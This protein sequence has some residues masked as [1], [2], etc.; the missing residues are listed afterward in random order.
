MGLKPTLAIPGSCLFYFI[1][2][3]D[4]VLYFFLNLLEIFQFLLDLSGHLAFQFVQP[5]LDIKKI[6]TLATSLE[7]KF[8]LLLCLPKIL[9]FDGMQRLML[10]KTTPTCKISI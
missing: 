4:S 5:N 1:S 10:T 7:L 6:C 9:L 2:T 3:L 8:L